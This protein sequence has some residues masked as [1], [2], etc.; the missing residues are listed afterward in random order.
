MKNLSKEINKVSKKLTSSWSTKR[1]DSSDL[2]VFAKRYAKLGW[3]IQ[4]QLENVLQMNF[5]DVNPNAVNEME[6]KLSGFNDEIDDAFDEYKEWL[7]SD[8]RNSSINW[9]DQRSAKREKRPYI[10][11]DSPS[12]LWGVW[13]PATRGYIVQAEYRSKRDA[14]KDASDPRWIV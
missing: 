1:I 13:V 4:E 10:K 3:S 6:D 11:Y 7:G 2:L 14:I 5:D 12:K 8:S 9:E